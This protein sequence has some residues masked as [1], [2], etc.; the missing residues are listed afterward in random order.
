MGVTPSTVD[1]TYRRNILNNFGM[2][3]AKSDYFYIFLIF[4]KKG[5]ISG[6]VYD[7]QNN[8]LY[9]TDEINIL[10]ESAGWLTKFLDE[11][12][13]LVK[14]T[15]PATTTKSPKI[16][17]KQEARQL[18]ALDDDAPDPLDDDYYSGVYGY[19]RYGGR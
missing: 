2:P 5:D 1:M 15:T 17:A 13:E 11:A 8:A 6:E 16:G 18:S 19:G 10:H 9:S 14:E 12:K 3:S 4:N 7:L